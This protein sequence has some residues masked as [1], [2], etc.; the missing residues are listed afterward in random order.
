VP[1][2]RRAAPGRPALRPVLVPRAARCRYFQELPFPHPILMLPA[3][4]YPQIAFTPSRL[5]LQL[6]TGKIRPN[7]PHPAASAMLR[8]ARR[9]LSRTFPASWPQAAA[10]SS[11]RVLR[12]VVTSPASIN[13]SRK[14]DT[15]FAEERLKPESGKG[16]NGIRLN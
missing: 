4:S 15:A 3:A 9:V 10:I 7:L 14:R 13:T 6:P 8:W 1:A 16:L 2:E 11:P 12:T 5:Q